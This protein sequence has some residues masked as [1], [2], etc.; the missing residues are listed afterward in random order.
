MVNGTPVQQL[1]QQQQLLRQARR[2][3][4]TQIKIQQEALQR[5]VSSQQIE[6][7]RQAAQTTVRREVTQIGSLISSQTDLLNTLQQRER[8]AI[9]NRDRLRREADQARGQA[10]SSDLIRESNLVTW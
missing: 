6:Q 3:T 7:E 9:Q 8:D 1:Q 10:V 5:G 2:V 4:P